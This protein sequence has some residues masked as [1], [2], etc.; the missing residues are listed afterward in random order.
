MDRGDDED[1]ALRSLGADLE[2]DDPRLA[3]LLSGERP[4]RSPTRWLWWL[5][6]VLAVG[7]LLLLPLTTAVG[8]VIMLLVLASPVAVCLMGPRLDGGRAPRG[9]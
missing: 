8:A 7:L 2:R 4:P 5:L 3:A 6:A 9:G 1:L